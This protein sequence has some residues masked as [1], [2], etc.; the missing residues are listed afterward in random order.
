VPS[1]LVSELTCEFVGTFVGTSA[2]GFVSLPP[3]KV[4]SCLAVG[5][6]VGFEVSLFVSSLALP[7]LRSLLLGSSLGASVGCNI[8]FR[9]GD[10]VNSAELII[11][12]LF[13]P[14]L[15]GRSLGNPLGSVLG[16]SLGSSDGIL[17]GNALGTELDSILSTWFGLAVGKVL[18]SK[19]LILVVIS[20]SER[21]ASPPT[22]PASPPPPIRAVSNNCRN[23]IL[24]TGC[25]N[26]VSSSSVPPT[27]LEV[28]LLPSRRC[29]FRTIISEK[30]STPKTASSFGHSF[31]HDTMMLHSVSRND[32]EES[33]PVPVSSS[34][35]ETESRLTSDMYRS[36][37]SLQPESVRLLYTAANVSSHNCFVMVLLSSLM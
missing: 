10:T 13:R 20:G 27:S 21:S 22:T 15:L 2:G 7:F 25:F 31:Q 9:V 30:S 28:V 5:T 12:A 23:S 8:S 14:R 24:F 29:R 26:V 32:D 37:N 4:L 11:F 33:L 17:L 19:L 6:S 34:S 16:I 35:F 18:G 3:G 1:I 36:Y